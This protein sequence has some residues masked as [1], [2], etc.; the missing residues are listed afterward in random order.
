MLASDVEKR[1]TSRV[2]VHRWDVGEVI[3]ADP[4]AAVIVGLIIL[5]DRP[6][7]FGGSLRGSGLARNAGDHMVELGPTNRA[8][9]SVLLSE[10]QTGPPVESGGV[11]KCRCNT[12]QKRF[13]SQSLLQ[14]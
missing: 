8:S 11:G 10:T 12:L 6:P 1:V 5:I 2:S 7:L 3:V 14:R 13:F 4:I 9:G